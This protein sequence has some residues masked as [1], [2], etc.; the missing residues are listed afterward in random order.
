MHRDYPASG[1]PCREGRG[2]RIRTIR[3]SAPLDGGA[4]P[5]DAAA[6]DPMAYRVFA[7]V[8][9]SAAS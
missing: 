1:G 9:L 5:H 6:R 7:D 3:A 4:E 8:G 2:L